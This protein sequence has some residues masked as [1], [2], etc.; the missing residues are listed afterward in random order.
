MFNGYCV[1]PLGVKRLGREAHHLPPLVALKVYRRKKLNLL[2]LLLL[3][4]FHCSSVAACCNSAVN[5]AVQQRHVATAQWTLQ[6]SSGM[7][8]QRSER[9]NSAAACCNSAVNAAVQ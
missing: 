6:F 8:Q 3:L 2:L 5:A 7:L 9:C 1:P 4:L